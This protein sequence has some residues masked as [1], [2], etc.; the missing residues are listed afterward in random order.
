MAQLAGLLS[1]THIHVSCFMQ[2][3][4]YLV[5][6]LGKGLGGSD[7]VSHALPGLA[8]WD[9]Q[10]VGN[11]LQPRLHLLHILVEGRDG[12]SQSGIYGPAHSCCRSGGR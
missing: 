10:L 3:H 8:L 6:L 7:V 12:T 4:A 11:V 2:E 9:A 1:H 5:W